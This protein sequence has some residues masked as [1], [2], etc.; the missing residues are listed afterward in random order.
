MK[1]LLVSSVFAILLFMFNYFFIKQETENSIL[2]I[3][4]QSIFSG[5]L[6]YGMF[7]L[8]TKKNNNESRY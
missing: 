7:F 5:A 1:L 6:F 8:L 4:F 2:K 3:G